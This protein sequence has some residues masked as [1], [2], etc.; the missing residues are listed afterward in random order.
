[1]QKAERYHNR[2]RG[3]DSAVVLEVCSYSVIQS[4]DNMMGDRSWHQLE[5]DDMPA[6]KWLLAAAIAD[7]LGDLVGT[8]EVEVAQWVWHWQKRAD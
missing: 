6:V 4:G 8:K 5:A 7:S 1:M 3:L 2:N